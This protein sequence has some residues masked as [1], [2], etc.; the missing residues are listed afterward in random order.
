[1]RRMAGEPPASAA[2][3]SIV[4]LWVG[5]APDAINPFGNTD[6]N[7]AEWQGYF[8]GHMILEKVLDTVVRKSMV[9]EVLLTGCSAGGM[10]TFYNCDFV[11]AK[12]PNANAQNNRSLFCPTSQQ[13]T[14]WQT[15]NL[16]PCKPS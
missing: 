8:Q 16:L 3:L 5:Q 6:G 7:A 11:A 13:C 2:Q 4:P 10:G 1:M 12:Y 14:H 9:E 15:N